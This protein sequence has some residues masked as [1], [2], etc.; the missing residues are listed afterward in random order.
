[1]AKRT[2]IGNDTFSFEGVDIVVMYYK[3]GGLY[4]ATISHV[5]E[6]PNGNIYRPGSGTSSDT[7]LDHLKY[8]IQTV[9]LS[10]FY[11]G[12]KMVFNEQF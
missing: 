2:Y 7:D 9:Y 1:M 3:E 10:N 6:E 5:I 4:S 11:E 12:C 8:K